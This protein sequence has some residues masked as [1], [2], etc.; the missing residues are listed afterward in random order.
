MWGIFH[1]AW[2]IKEKLLILETLVVQ[3][4]I[5]YILKSIRWLLS[6]EKFVSMSTFKNQFTFLFNNLLFSVIIIISFCALV[7]FFHNILFYYRKF[8]YFIYY[9]L[10]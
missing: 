1:F 5:K 2:K 9:L 10:S 4:Q 3:I 7:F 6:L 8:T